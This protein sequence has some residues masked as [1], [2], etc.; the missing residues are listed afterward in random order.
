[1]CRIAGYVRKGELEA[2]ADR[3]IAMTRAMAHGGPDGEGITLLGPALNSIVNLRT[4]HSPRDF[5]GD[6]AFAAGKSMPHR[7]AFG[8]RRFSI[9][10]L[11]VAG[12]QPFWTPDRQTCVSFNGEI[13]NYLE[14][15]Q[16]LESA[17]HLFLTNS[18]TEVL[19]HGYAEWGERC[20]ERM[21]GFWAISLYDAAKEAV[22]ISRD[23]IGR[24]PLYVTSQPEGV[25][26]ASEIKA[27]HAAL[28]AERFAISGQ[29][30]H[31][32]VKHMRRDVGD[33]T[34]YEGIE[35]LPNAS[36]AWI[37][38]DGS[39]ATPKTYWT[40]PTERRTEKEISPDEAVRTLREL[41]ED[42]LRLQLRA[43]VPVGFE[44]SGGLDSSALTGFAAKTR[45]DMRVYT[46]SF[47]GTD[48]DE[49]P[50]ARAVA[51]TYKDRITYTVLHPP[52]DDLFERADGY[53]RLLDEPFH[54]PNMRTNQSIWC[55][56]AEQG[57]KVSINGGGCDEVLAGYPYE[58]WH[59]YL[60]H[61]L[62]TGK[63]R[64]FWR[65][66][67]RCTEVNK[68]KER[69]KWLLLLA[70][71]KLR[72]V[73]DPK[74]SITQDIDPFVSHG[75][76]ETNA[77]PSEEIH[78]RMF[79]N[80]GDWLMNYWMR[81]SNLSFMGVP[82]EVR[83]PLLDHRIVEF[84][85]TL[86]LS[87]LMRDGWMKWLLRKACEGV[88]PDEVIW[89]RKKQGFPFPYGEWCRDSKERFFEMV[90][91]I[92]C[93]YIDMTKMREHYDTICAKKPVYLWRLM[94]LALWWKRC[95]R[96]ER[97]QAGGVKEDLEIPHGAGALP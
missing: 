43:D 82:V 23:R 48:V 1:M 76:H 3:I 13:F 53:F 38:A 34:F 63:W 30:V 72:V 57:I 16:E 90:G 28:G 87:Y 5:I 83:Q 68:P 22:L 24:S 14:L 56:M 73:K 46:I 78:R 50:F 6:A 88:L 45:V 35:M 67:S 36:Y 65:E 26:W 75:G 54:S 77:A 71:P 94:C 7:I 49:E 86:P 33:K 51:E 95:V 85:Y 8:H 20:F 92:D 21:N 66:F 84:A 58:Y 61:L 9:I 27:L 11:S 55:S 32:Y 97:L 69:L 37:D 12:H 62:K 79:D 29:A 52:Q 25:F 18:D 10:D 80:M 15:K 89:R 47:K 42:A 59:P 81:S 64:T 39:M 60:R 2:N 31:D 40:I 96:G 70:P 17:G 74:Y 44:L 4:D 19:V 93:P 91:D 41:I